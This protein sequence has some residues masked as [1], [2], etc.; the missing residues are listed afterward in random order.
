MPS[1]SI[2]SLKKNIFKKHHEEKIFDELNVDSL[3]SIYEHV[4]NNSEEKESS[5]WVM[6]DVAASLKDSSIQKILKEM[7]YN[8]RH[9][10]LSIFMLV[11]SYSTIPKMIRRTINNIFLWKCSKN[12]FEMIFE[13]LF[14]NKRDMTDKILK[15]INEPHKWMLL[16]FP[17]QRIFIDFDEV[18]VNEN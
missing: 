7:I 9:L 6:D 14:E 1:H 4:K 11:Q 18:I 3:T 17:S 5:L 16:N 13:E 15:L 2:A 8:R 10:K 12:E